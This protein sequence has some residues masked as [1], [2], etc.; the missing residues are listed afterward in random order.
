MIMML[1]MT[2]VTE[3]LALSASYHINDWFTLSFQSSFAW[4]QSNGSVFDYEVADVGGAMT[5]IV[6]Y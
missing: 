6:R 5:L 4:N 3:I 2:D 1:P